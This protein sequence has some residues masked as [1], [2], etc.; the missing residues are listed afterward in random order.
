[1]LTT[2]H[3]RA[4]RA[5]DAAVLRFNIAKGQGVLELLRHVDR[6]DGFGA[7][8]LRV[9]VDAPA[10]ITNYGT[11]RYADD[12]PDSTL[13]QAV[14]GSWVVQTLSVSPV[15][16]TLVAL[17]RPGDLLEQ[18]WQ[19]DNRNT[20]LTRVR[21]TKHDLA[22]RIQRPRRSG[23]R[24]LLTVRLDSVVVDPY[25]TADPVRRS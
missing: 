8:T 22:V 14:A 18:I 24:R 16:A 9:S 25:S 11:H 20:L 4:M 23:S 15:W 2:A 21:L 10:V 12:P 3:L 1:M 5:A 7:D 13:A 17:M 19:I 6:T